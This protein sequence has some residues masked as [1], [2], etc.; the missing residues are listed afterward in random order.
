MAARRVLIQR[1]D[2]AAGDPCADVE[3]LQKSAP[4]FVVTP[5][6]R[7]GS[8]STGGSTRDAEPM[9]RVTVGSYQHW[10]MV[11]RPAP[12]PQSTASDPSHE[13]LRDGRSYGY[14]TP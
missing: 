1:A 4:E 12:R 13:E 8:I 9:A 6:T 14:L 2:G 3:A 7:T 10:R 5:R 11:T